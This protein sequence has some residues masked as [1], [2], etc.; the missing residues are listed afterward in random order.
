MSQSLQQADAEVEARLVPSS[1]PERSALE[2]FLDNFFREENIKWMS[3]IGAAIILGSSLMLVSHQWKSWPSEIKYLAI[4]GYTFGAFGCAQLARF[5]FGLRTTGSVLQLLTLLLMP[6]CFMALSWLQTGNNQWLVV[7]ET[8]A[9]MVPAVLLMRYATFRIF[10]HFL[11]ERQSTFAYCYMLLCMACALPAMDSLPLASAFAVACWAVMSVGVLKVNRHIFWMTEEHKQPRVFAF[12]PIALLGAQFLMLVVMKSLPVIPYEWLGLGCVMVAATVLMTARTVADVFKQRT[13]DLVRPLPWNLVLPLFVGLALLVSGVA[14]SFYGFSFRGPTTFAVV[15]TALVAGILLCVVAWD[16]RLSGFAWAALVLLTM[17]YQASPTLVAELVQTLKQHAASAVNESSLPIAFYGITYLPL[18][19]TMMIASRFCDSRGRVRHERLKLF[20]A[21][22]RQFSTLLTALLFV[23]AAFNLKAL[24]IVS[25]LDVPLLLSMA[26][27]FRDRRYAYGSLGCLVLASGLFVP[28]INT[29]GL[30]AISPWHSITAMAV[31]GFALVAV[32]GLDRGLLRIPMPSH[33][34]DRAGERSTSPLAVCM[35]VGYAM[36]LGL[37][38]FWTVTLLQSWPEVSTLAM[39]QLGLLLSTLLIATVRTRD[40]LCGIHFWLLGGVG[41]M[42]ALAKVDLPWTV[43]VE[44]GSVATVLVSLGGYFAVQ[45]MRRNTEVTLSGIRRSSANNYTLQSKDP[46]ALS[47]SRSNDQFSGQAQLAATLLVSL[48]D[49]SLAIAVCLAALFHIPALALINV[50]AGGLAFPIATSAMVVWGFAIAW[51]FRS[52]TAGAITAAVVPLWG[53]ALL[54]TYT[55]DA[56]PS[57]WDITSFSIQSLVWTVCAGGTAL[58]ASMRSS[59]PWQSVCVTSQMWLAVLT[60]LSLFNADP[61]FR[62]VGLLGL[63]IGAALYKGHAGK[64]QP[65]IVSILANLHI[66]ILVLSL[67]GIESWFHFWLFNPQLPAAIATLLPFVALSIL[68]FDMRSLRLDGNVCIVW[69]AC[70]RNLAFGIL[71]LA[72][73]LSGTLVHLLP[74]IV[75]GMVILAVAEFTQAVRHQA[76]L[77]VWLGLS[78]LGAAAIWLVFVGAIQ[79]GAGFSQ[80]AL[81]IAAAVGLLAAHLLSG[82]KRYGVF[83]HPMLCIGL[84]CPAVLT[85]IAILH[86]LVSSANMVDPLGMLAMFGAAMVYFHQGL[87]RKQRR[88]SLMAVGIINVALMLTWQSLHIYDAQAYCI[89]VGLSVIGIVQLLKRE[90][91]K[92]AHD[93]LRYVG[94]LVMLVSPM[95]EIISGSWLH[96][97]TLLALSVCVILLA[98]GLRLRALI[99][100]GA[101]FLLAD[102]VMMVVRSSIDHP[103]LLWVCGLGLGGAVIALAAVCERHREQVLSRIRMLSAELATWN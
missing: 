37:A 11:R 50:T 10:D 101:A 38:A 17:A 70:L 9:L 56:M 79:V 48:S 6:L 69:S 67:C 42:A 52:R 53:W 74:V 33:K 36:T 31:I 97:F 63:A 59:R 75:L 21:P 82:H 45:R 76:E 100:T 24:A 26:I 66:F 15:P 61:L 4:L 46:H 20:S 62:V 99:H 68:L 12:I 49:L 91:P 65:T 72:F 54:A 44:C 98:I 41:A 51:I 18:I 88:Y 93:P 27:L 13:G 8:V 25:I 81:A 32:P 90:L 84:T 80:L 77:F 47:P 29:V 60:V 96:L 58:I 5:R 35:V 43:M 83:A 85:S 7:T 64:L 16:T 86:E 14:I 95:F 28:L 30:A 1:S 94:A 89:P 55:P 39:C 87:V 103:S 2:R 23:V 92:S 19:V 22:L 102:L 57:G 3:V 78:V 40:Y 73:A 71:I 34:P